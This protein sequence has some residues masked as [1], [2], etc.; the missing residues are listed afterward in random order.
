MAHRHSTMAT[1]ANQPF[2]REKIFLRYFRLAGLLSPSN[3]RINK[4]NH[5]PF[6]LDAIKKPMQ[7]FT[8]ILLTSAARHT[9]IVY[10]MKM[11]LICIQQPQCIC[12][13]I[14]TWYYQSATLM[15]PTIYCRMLFTLHISYAMWFCFH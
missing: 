15:D 7:K 3:L 2:P 8:S 9:L 4:R 10:W 13:V 5:W 6:E 12:V 14:I 1:L 11:S